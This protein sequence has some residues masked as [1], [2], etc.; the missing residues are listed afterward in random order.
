VLRLEVGPQDMEFVDVRALD[1]SL[2]QE[3]ICDE[4]AVRLP[5]PHNFFEALVGIKG[6][7]FAQVVQLLGFIRAHEL[8]SLGFVFEELVRPPAKLILTASELPLRRILLLKKFL[9][10]LRKLK[11]PLLERSEKLL[12]RVKQLFQG[13]LFTPEVLQILIDK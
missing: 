2:R 8:E 6:Q 12:S 10:F 13:V 7:L 1:S 3:P 5:H 9:F 4:P 11:L